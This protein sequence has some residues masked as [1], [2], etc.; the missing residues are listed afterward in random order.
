L[1]FNLETDHSLPNT[2][3]LFLFVRNGNQILV[4]SDMY[5]THTRQ[6]ANF[7]QPSVTLTKYQKGYV[8]LRVQLDVLFICILYSSLFLAL[9]VAGGIYTH[10]QENKLQRTAIG[11]YN[12]FGMLIDWIR[13]WLGHPHTFSTVLNVWGCPSQ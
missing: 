10:P 11:V 8:H 3:F 4:D 1:F 12:G 2:F 5:Y 13:Y 9:H 7:H 6:H